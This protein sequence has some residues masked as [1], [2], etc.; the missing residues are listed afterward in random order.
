MCLIPLTFP[1]RDKHYLEFCFQSSWIFCG[2]L[3]S[4]VFQKNLSVQ[5]RCM[6]VQSS[7]I[8]HTKISILLASQISIIYL[9][10][11]MNQSYNYYKLNPILYLDSLSCLSHGQTRVVG[12]R[13][14]TTVISIISAHYVK[15]TFCQH[16]VSLMMLSFIP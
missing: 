11:L 10:K 9:T 1:A 7:H 14:K 3:I 16:A 5:E 8:S 2:V 4:F 13:R 12:W 15:G 6:K